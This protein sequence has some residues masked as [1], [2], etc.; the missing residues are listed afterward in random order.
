MLRCFA[1]HTF[2]QDAGADAPSTFRRCRGGYSEPVAVGIFIRL[3]APDNIRLPGFV[4]SITVPAEAAAHD[5]AQAVRS[6]LRVDP[7]AVRA[8][9]LQDANMWVRT[10][11]TRNFTR[12]LFASS[13]AQSTFGRLLNLNECLLFERNPLLSVLFTPGVREKRSKVRVPRALSDVPGRGVFGGRSRQSTCR[14]LSPGM[15]STFS[16]HLPFRKIRTRKQGTLEAGFEPADSGYEP[17][18]KP[19]LFAIA[20]GASQDTVFDS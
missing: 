14:S 13:L 18:A 7:I 19:Q 16:P 17:L 9:V 15:R 4:P 8:F 20:V 6:A 3:K 10:Y 11:L 1:V 5:Q 12:L 2:S